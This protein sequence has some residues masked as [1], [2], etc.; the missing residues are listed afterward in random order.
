MTLDH[1][2]EKSDIASSLCN[3]MRDF[4]QLCH[5]LSALAEEENNRIMAE[6]FSPD[7]H[8]TVQKITMLKTF[9]EEAPRLSKRI[10]TELWDHEMLQNHFVK[11]IEDLQRKLRINTSLQLHTMEQIQARKRKAHEGQVDHTRKEWAV[12]H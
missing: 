7:T 10:S 2:L 3:Q 4:E 6:T 1:I 12:C 11:M 9:E 8:Y 5:E